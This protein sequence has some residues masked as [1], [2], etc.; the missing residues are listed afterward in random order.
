V[1][2]LRDNPPPGFGPGT[3]GG[4]FF[5]GAY[6]APRRS[7]DPVHV[8]V[9]SPEQA[10]QLFHGRP[11]T[12]GEAEAIAEQSYPW[13]RHLHDPDSYWVTT[14]EAGRILG[15]SAHQVKRLLDLHRLPYIHHASGVRLMRRSQIEML[16]RGFAR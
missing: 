11:V 15:L 13:R 7:F 6:S 2:H 3:T 14:S 5:P 4:S 12:P 9:C 10:Y 16:A 8:L 1:N